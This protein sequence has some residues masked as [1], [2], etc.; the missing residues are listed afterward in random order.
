MPDFSAPPVGLATATPGE[1]DTPHAFY[2]TAPDWTGMDLTTSRQVVPFASTIFEQ[3][4][5]Y[6]AMPVTFDVQTGRVLNPDGRVFLLRKSFTVEADTPTT[7]QAIAYANSEFGT[8][9]N[10]ALGMVNPAEA[11]A[12]A[13]SMAFPSL[14]VRAD[15]GGALGIILEDDIDVHYGVTRLV[16]TYTFF[17]GATMQANGLDVGLVLPYSSAAPVRVTS[18]SLMIAVISSGDVAPGAA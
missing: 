18:G 15:V 8:A 17:G 16:R 6:D 11:R 9:M 1:P 13:L 2:K 3:P 14:G 12:L 7:A 4:G 5:Q 10:E